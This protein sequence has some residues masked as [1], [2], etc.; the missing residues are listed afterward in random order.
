MTVDK[1]QVRGDGLLNSCKAARP[2]G[3]WAISDASAISEA[4]IGIQMY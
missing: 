4:R 3:Q 2:L 1:P